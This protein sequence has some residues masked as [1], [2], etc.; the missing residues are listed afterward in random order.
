[1]NKLSPPPF[2]RITLSRAAFNLFATRAKRMHVAVERNDGKIDLGV[3][4]NTLDQLR[5]AA[6]PKEN[7]SDTII[8]LMSPKQEVK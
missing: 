1:M 5:T 8:R 4:F 3:S 2:Y 7:L 6:L